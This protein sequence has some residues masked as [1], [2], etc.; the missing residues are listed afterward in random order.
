MRYT[1]KDYQADAVGDVLTNLA[2]AR[3]IYRDYGDPSQF[4]LTATTGAGKTVMAAA[5]IE[6]L[7]YGNDS[8]DFEPDRTAVVLWFS[9]DPSLNEQTRIRLEAASEKL[10]SDTVVIQHPFKHPKLSAGKIYF[11]NTHKLTKSSLLTRGHESAQDDNQIELVRASSLPDRQEYTIW[12][13][14]ANT[15][16]DP[17]LTLYMVL[18]EA[19]RGMGNQSA[20]KPTIVKRL[21]NGQG[22]V[23][24]MPVVWG[25][26][27]TVQRFEDA[28]KA[29]E[30]S[31]SRIALPKVL[32]DPERVQ[33]SGL[34]KDDIV[35]DI[36]AESGAFDSV[37]LSRAT[38]K[39]VESTKAWAAYAEEQ[40]DADAVIPLMVLQSPNTPA[41]DMLA[42][43]LDTIFANWPDLRPDSVAHVL[44]DHS[45]QQW[46][47]YHVPYIAPERVQDAKHVRVLIA[48]DAISTGWDCP[49]AEVL[50]SFRPAKD[51]TH[52]T[53]LLGRMVRTPLARR[54]PGSEKLNSVECILPFFDRRTATNVVKILLGTLEEFPESTGGRRVLIDPQEMTPNPAIPEEVWE[55]LEGLPSQS[56]PKRGTKPVK[57]LTALAHALAADGL[58]PEAGKE[59]HS[60]M[61][62]VLDGLSVRYKDKLAEAVAE[63]W[64]V[65]GETIT[66]SAGAE[67]P[68]YSAF[69]ETADDRAIRDAFR[70]AG[71]VLSPDLA[72]T[73]VDHLAGPDD[74]DTDDDGLRDAHV[75]VAA[76]ALVPEVREDLDR[77]ADKLAAKWFDE[78]R[79]AVKNLTDERQA[80]YNDI[81][82]MSIE[83]QR[84]SITRPRSAMVE[85]QTRDEE[86][87]ARP[88]PTQPLHLL[89]DSAGQY[90]V[91]RPVFNSWELDVID[92]ELG[93]PGVI[94]WYRN[95]QRASQES[96]GVAY[97]DRKG[98]WRSMRPDFVFFSLTPNGVK[99]SI[100]DPHSDY[101]GDALPKLRGLAAFAAE[102]GDEFHR[103]EA[104]NKVGNQ[105]RVLDLKDESVRLAVD[106]A[107]SP[108]ML[109]ESRNAANY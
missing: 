78:Y 55:V 100:V 38:R 51:A 57:R 16:K 18:D 27:A 13:T 63:I 96:L 97:K 109:Y 75:K 70:A 14:L 36:P 17:N 85:T 94:A 56:L 49:R 89:S 32:V 71:R 19:H 10:E 2:K 93:R 35:L 73:Y 103:I 64:T 92:K 53:Q 9:D 65:R 12:G 39:I 107:D 76:L 11:L 54:I 81:R 22:D 26:S 8:L 74:P 30:V 41:S 28:M 87:N 108:E 5:A 31:A 1:L 77:E 21:I 44:G 69:A 102:F 58:R 106:T 83:P 79:V 72:G 20:D 42:R 29:A 43:A 4:A 46:G 68:V 88:M 47:M 99:A 84:L 98:T 104:I 48:K 3:N 37:L 25:I 60:V 7:F 61:H 59:A 82:A 15:I 86:G 45:P 80:V 91:G 67:A 52:I 33:E 6:A 95:P 23:P 34:L 90:P 40:S 66:G 62:D 101:L 105:L 24:A 50:V